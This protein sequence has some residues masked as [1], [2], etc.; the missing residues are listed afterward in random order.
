M[1]KV[2]T[3]SPRDINKVI[4]NIKR[5]LSS[6][7]RDLEDVNATGI[8][9]NTSMMVKG[10]SMLFETKEQAQLALDNP[11]YTLAIQ[12]IKDLIEKNIRN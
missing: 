1:R 2:K 7:N 8:V 3:S 10:P 12:H 6:L 4:S 9:R 5:K 11:D